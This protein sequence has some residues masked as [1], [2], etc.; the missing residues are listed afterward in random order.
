M[1]WLLSLVSYGSSLVMRK[2]QS[3]LNMDM[4][5]LESRLTKEIRDLGERVAKIDGAIFHGVVF[6]EGNP[7]GTF[8]D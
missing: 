1:A 3:S 4:G 6:K 5:N 7:M 8:P 2:L